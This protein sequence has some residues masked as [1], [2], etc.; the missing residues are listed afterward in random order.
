M[1]ASKVAAARHRLSVDEARD[2]SVRALLGIGYTENRPI[3]WLATCSMPLCAA[4][5]IP[6]CPRF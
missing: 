2:L 6:D 5:N 1:M 4:T 3:S